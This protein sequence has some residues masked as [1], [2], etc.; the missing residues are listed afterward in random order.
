MSKELLESPFE[1]RTVP[2]AL[3][4]TVA[5][6]P[7][8]TF[9][10]CGEESL[11]FRQ[12]DLLT[13]RFAH[14]LRSLPIGQGKLAIMVPNSLEFVYGW[15]GCAKL[16]TV[17]V[18]I[19]NEYR[20]DI[21]Q[22]QLAKADVTHIL[23]DESYLGRLAE[24]IGSL[25]Q[26][27]AVIVRGN[28][29]AAGAEARQS[30]ATRAQVIEAEAFRAHPD[31]PVNATVKYT[32]K[33]SISFTSGTTGPSKG[34]LSTHC[35]VVSF[36][37]DWI[38]VTRFTEQDVIF[39]PMPLFHAL[40]SI[41]GVLPAVI[42]GARIAL[43]PRFSASTY[44]DEVRKHG[45]TIAHGIFSVIPLLLKQAERPDDRDHP[46]RVFYIGQRNEDF[47]RRFGV[48][49]V[50]AYGATETGA[51]AYTPYEE[52]APAG[53][54]GKPNLAKYDVRIV[55]DNDQ[56]VR[57]GE[58]GEV[59]VRPKRPFMLMDGYY[60][61]PAAT[62][63]AFRNLWFHTGDNVRQDAGGWIYFV[64][65]K[66]DAIRRRGENIASFDIES[67]VNLHPGVLESAAVAIPSELSE[68]D[69][70]VF[71]VRKPGAAVSQQELHAFCEQRMPGF[72]LPRVIEFIEEMPRTPTQKIMK[73]RLR[74]DRENGDKVEFPS[75]L[76]KTA[77]KPVD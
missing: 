33:H 60:N 55:D 10:T 37:Y 17:F 72:W 57:I 56:E 19:N 26:L 43:A 61:D 30:L 42:C 3:A 28:I 21:L 68:D 46:A 5:R 6:V 9:I 2:A 13:N 39:A 62:V 77:R 11:T 8:R 58:V 44:W 74:E 4:R 50:N 29:A 66:K 69:V 31:T 75:A 40:G 25:P 47:E 23:I 51:V 73:Y 1:Q 12:F 16:G 54:C 35:H 22:Y 14:F 71:V 36:S 70:K 49:V 65:R 7:D 20:G 41:L 67:V 18:P 45:A 38:E 64:D 52:E 34:V 59:I 32:D 24:V 15:F 48:K 53:S 63:D 27:R 76:R